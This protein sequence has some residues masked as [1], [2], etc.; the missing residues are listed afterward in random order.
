MSGLLSDNKRSRA[1]PSQSL[2]KS[3]TIDRPQMMY[4]TSG[5]DSRES[6]LEKVVDRRGGGVVTRLSV[7]L[8][9]FMY[10]GEVDFSF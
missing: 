2:W 5:L 6:S 4:S 1:F 9:C 8:M 10:K 3:G 7:E